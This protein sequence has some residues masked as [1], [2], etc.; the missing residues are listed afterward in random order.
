MVLKEASRILVFDPIHGAEV[1]ASELNELGKEAEV[2]NP[3][4]ESAYTKR[5]NHD[6]VI[7]PVHLSPTFEIV[8]QAFRNNIPFM[9]HHDAVKEI[10]AVKNL[11]AD[12]KVV[13]VTGTIGK[14]STCELISQ[15]LE[16]QRVLLHTSSSTR[17]MSPDG[18]ENFPRLGGTPANVLKVM[19]LAR[20]KNV[21]PEIAVFEISLGLTGIGDVGVLTSVKEDYRIAGGTKDASAVKKVSTTYS[22]GRSIIVHPGLSLPLSNSRENI[23]GDS[24]KNLWIDGNENNVMIS[25]LKTINGDSISGEFAFKPLDSYMSTEFY[26]DSL[27]AA[28]CAVLSLGIPPE[29]LNT[30]VTS[31]T[32]RMKLEELQGRFLIDNSNSGTKL[33]FLGEVMAMARR[34][35]DKMILIVGEESKYVCEGMR[36]DELKKVVEEKAADFVEIIIV[37]EEFFGKIEGENTFFS[38]NLDFA[39]EKAFRDSEEGFAI[40]SNVKTWR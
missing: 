36:S 1:I 3:Y 23:F 15:L 31:V 4:R 30:I 19:E 18:T 29:E 26:R 37:G 25:R 17:F 34:L 39:L 27:E 24:N 20:E 5:L 2:F 10:A 7:S 21:K 9:S 16:S 11:F 33:K 32:G 38:T 12:I 35:S 13:E 40:I 8:K 6:L 22:G 14:T 28:F